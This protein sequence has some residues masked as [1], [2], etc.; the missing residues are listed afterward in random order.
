MKEKWGKS[1]EVLWMK[2]RSPERNTE[3]FEKGF[4]E[5][6]Q[7]RKVEKKEQEEGRKGGKKKSTNQILKG[8][9]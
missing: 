3:E 1:C 9:T 2:M 5:E 6:Q 4:A 7:E 8:I